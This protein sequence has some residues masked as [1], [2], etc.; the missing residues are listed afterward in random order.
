LCDDDND[1]DDDD[2]EDRCKRDLNIKSLSF[3]QIL[4]SVLETV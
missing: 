2:D 3:I 1:D 4:C